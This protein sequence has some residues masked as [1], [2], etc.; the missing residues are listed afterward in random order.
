MRVAYVCADRGVPVFGRKGCSVHVQEILRAMLRRG[1]T[2]DLF[3]SRIDG[4][5]PDDL[6]SVRV[7]RLPTFLPRETAQSAA[8]DEC[9]G[10]NRCLQGMLEK[11]GPFDLIY[12]RYSLWSFAAQ[13]FARSVGV[14]SI[15]E[16]NA[17]LID[18]QQ[19]YR[20]LEDPSLAY[21]TT[22]KAF[23]AATSL[24]AVSREVADCVASRCDDS[25]RVHV[26]SN[27]V[28]AERFSQ[29]R[30]PASDRDAFTVGFVGTL[31][32]WHG[33]E[34]LVEA[35]A[36]AVESCPGMR[37]RIVGDGP[38]RM[39]LQERVRRR[40]P[41]HGNAVEFSGAV[42]H[43]RVPDLLSTIDAAV[44]PYPAL[45]DFYFS[46]LKIYEYM[47]AGCSVVASRVGAC[48]RIISDGENGLLCEAGNAADLARVLQTLYVDRELC[49]DLGK[50]ARQTA[51][52]EYTWRDVLRRIVATTDLASE[53]PLAGAAQ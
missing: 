36:M 28:N 41:Q 3:A 26:V 50:R 23:N 9:Y 51:M 21:T 47:A 18:E 14:C 46:P 19:R 8:R 48:A 5:P 6:L 42:D 40:I 38:E 13:E 52:T 11:E 30:R 29:V 22:D 39:S 45:D 15:L 31:K 12:E 2:V 24:V 53:E 37:L 44:A 7:H 33:V 1:W 35:F 32:P 16:V 10:A 27:G 25:Q 43:G 20:T 4:Q 34:T 17:P 49:R